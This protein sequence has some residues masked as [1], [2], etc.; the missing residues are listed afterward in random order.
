MPQKVFGE[1][2]LP[3]INQNLEYL[4]DNNQTANQADGRIDFDRTSRDRIFFRYSVL[5]SINDNATNV[6]QFFQ[7][8]NADS[9]TFDQNMQVSDL[10][11]ISTTKMNEVR[12]AYNRSN[13]KTSN[14]TEFENWNNQFGIP[15]GN[16]GGPQSEGLAE[17]DMDGV[18]SVNGAS[19]IAQPDWVGYIFSNTIGLTDNFT[20][21][22]GQARG[23]VRHQ[24]QSR[25]GCFRRYDRRRQSTGRA[26]LQ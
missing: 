13:V 26:H 6:N 20:W 1:A 16:P 10:F 18:P 23:E 9:R 19:A 17:F 7:D 24:H 22:K 5:S 12:L 4:Y 11:S 21:I 2:N 3:G 15:N 8:G 25:A 14:K